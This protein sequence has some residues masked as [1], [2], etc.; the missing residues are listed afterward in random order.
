MAEQLDFIPLARAASLAHSRVYPG[1]SVR[2]MKTLDLLALALSEVLPLYQQENE[3]E[4][5]RL[6]EKSV[7][8]AGRFTRGATRLEFAGRPPLRF[9]VIARRDLSGALE[10]IPTLRSRL[11]PPRADSSPPAP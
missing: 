2:D 5:P 8:A 4:A 6:V 9:L 3:K 11:P 10:T 1:Q 7:I